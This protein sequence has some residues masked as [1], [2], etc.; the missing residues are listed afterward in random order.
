MLYRRIRLPTTFSQ[1]LLAL[2]SL[3]YRCLGNC[4]LSF[5]YLAVD[6][7]ASSLMELLLPMENYFYNICTLKVLVGSKHLDQESLLRLSSQFSSVLCTINEDNV[8][9]AQLHCKPRIQLQDLYNY[10]L[11]F[12]RVADFIGRPNLDRY[13]QTVD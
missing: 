11:C 8:Y 3:G 5:C 2:H 13:F 12:Y 4:S 10:W 9:L 6:H 1:F 7:L